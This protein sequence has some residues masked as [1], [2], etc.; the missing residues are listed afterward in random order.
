MSEKQE[1]TFDPASPHSTFLEGAWGC[2]REK[3]AISINLEVARTAV[4]AAQ[5]SP[6]ML[7]FRLTI[8]VARRSLLIQT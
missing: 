7:V 8:N 1:E 6:L 2:A 3:I 4:K 5:S